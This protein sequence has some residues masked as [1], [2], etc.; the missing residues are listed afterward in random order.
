MFFQQHDMGFACF[1]H[2]NLHLFLILKNNSDSGSSC[3]CKQVG[4]LFSEYQN[5]GQHESGPIPDFDLGPP[6][7]RRVVTHGPHWIPETNSKTAIPTPK[8]NFIFQPQ[9][10]GD[11]QV[12]SLLVSGGARLGQQRLQKKDKLSDPTGSQFGSQLSLPTSLPKSMVPNGYSKPLA[13]EARPKP[14]NEIGWIFFGQEIKVVDT[15]DGRNHEKP[16]GCIKPGK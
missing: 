4:R 8:G 14:S 13:V 3:C 7:K 11:F 6:K 2:L 1:L 15:V 16:P 10:V 5:V 12:N 9:P